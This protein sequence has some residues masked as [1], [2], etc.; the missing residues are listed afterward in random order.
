MKNIQRVDSKGR[1]LPEGFSERKGEG[2]YIARFTIDGERYIMY[3][4]N[5]AELKKAVTIRKADLQR[6]VL[7]PDKIVLNEWFE[8]WM[9]TYKKDQI[10]NQTYVNYKL[11]YDWYV[12][13]SLGNKPLC[14][15]KKTHVVEFCKGLLDREKP[16]AVS[17]VKYIG[18]LLYCCL[19]EAVDN[20]LIN[21]N[22]A[23]NVVNNLVHAD[24]IKKAERDSLTANEERILIDYISK[25]R[26]FQ[27]HENLIAVMLKTGM[28]VG[29]IC[30]LTWN[31]IDFKLEMINIDKT[32]SYRKASATEG[33][34]K[35][36][37]PTKTKMSKR[38]IPMIPEVKE[39]FMKQ[40]EM[41]TLIHRKCV[42]TIDGYTDFVF[43]SEDGT[44][45]YPDY[46][47]DIIKKITKSY[48]RVEEKEA[49]EEEREAILLPAFT[50]H[51]LR[52]TFRSRCFEKGMRNEVVHSIMGHSPGSRVSEGIYL[53][54]P[55]E[56]MEQELELFS[57]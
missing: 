55:L 9:D 4:S 26:F 53:H 41:L 25:H 40:R 34:V 27:Y 19:E 50:A 20:E 33:R 8:R 51:W 1:K 47:T 49:K 15:I 17:T 6:G 21:R 37:G 2:R 12:R 38:K 56:I 39:A 7:E 24:N 54:I 16:L 14:K 35:K 44:S 5:L 22:P 46:V 52:H 11:Y 30:A 28:R 31:D 36:V 48:N 18:S 42:D 32:L 57:K 29:E 3:G 10:R 23:K 43:L 13:N 45:L